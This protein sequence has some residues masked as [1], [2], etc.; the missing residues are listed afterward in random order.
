[1]CQQEGDYE[2]ASLIHTLY[3]CPNA[4]SIIKYI[5][6]ELTKQTTIKPH[7]IILTNAKCTANLGNKLK[8]NGTHRNC[9]VLKDYNENPT[10]LDYIWKI[11]SHYIMECHQKQEEILPKTA[12]GLIL[13]EY[14]HFIHSRS[15]NPISNYIRKLILNLK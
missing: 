11:A 15:S 2:P 14:Q 10:A 5:C 8:V 6:K 3:K 13:V 7:E 9:S 4:Q 1:M 12:L